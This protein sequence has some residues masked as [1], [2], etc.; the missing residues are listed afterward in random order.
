MIDELE[1]EVIE[2]RAIAVRSGAG[3]LKSLEDEI[4]KLKTELND[5]KNQ[6]DELSRESSEFSGCLMIPYLKLNGAFLP[7]GS[8]K[9]STSSQLKE[10]EQKLQKSLDEHKS[11]IEKIKLLEDKYSKSDMTVSQLTFHR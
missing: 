5:L 7:T 4:K 6:N 1:D 11:F 9:E 8:K 10:A 3:Q 2:M